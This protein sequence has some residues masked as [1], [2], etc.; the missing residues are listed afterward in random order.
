VIFDD[1]DSDE[2]PY[3]ARRAEA[4]ETAK[5]RAREVLKRL[6]QRDEEVIAVVT[7]QWLLRNGF[8]GLH[9]GSIWDLSTKHKDHLSAIHPSPRSPSFP[10]GSCVV[11][12]VLAAPTSEAATRP[13]ARI[14]K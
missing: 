8:F 1:P 12:E 14:V 6:L 2:D 7:H 4:S 5:R 10:V 11:V 9:T 13:T 3:P